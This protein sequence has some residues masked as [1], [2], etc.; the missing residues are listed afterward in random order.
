MA[1]RAPLIYPRNMATPSLSARDFEAPERPKF[2]ILSID[3]GGIRGL[4]PAV[5]LERLERLLQA[6]SPGAT[7]ASSF[8]LISGTSTGG[9][10]ALGLTTPDADGGPALDPAAMIDLYS[11]PEAQEIFE[12]PALE[13]LPGIG[14]VSE[15][16]DPR[17][18]LDG[19]RKALEARF[20]DRR[21]S[22]ALTGS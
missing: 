1:E 5:V 4:I 10:I 13:R 7:L 11:G 3:G 12:R 8:D 15:L 17:Y 19:L 14:K 21:I 16:L 9:L 18:G 6:D 22:E 20:G 2:R